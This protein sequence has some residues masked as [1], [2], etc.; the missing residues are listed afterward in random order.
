MPRTKG[1]KNR[2]KLTLEE[3]IAA[4]EERVV[5]AQAELAA[6]EEELKNLN[7]LRDEEQVKA[8]MDAIAASGRTIPEVIAL[9][10]GEEPGETPE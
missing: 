5:Q 9:I 6:A 8:L 4:A 10:Q 3:Q 1:S 2:S 7:A